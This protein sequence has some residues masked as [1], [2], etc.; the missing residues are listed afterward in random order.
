MVYDEGLPEDPASCVVFV[1]FPACFVSVLREDELY[2][3]PLCDEEFAIMHTSVQDRRNFLRTII[4][5]GRI[6]FLVKVLRKDVERSG[7]EL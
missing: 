1:L 2:D 5:R 7:I 4:E 3:S 6:E